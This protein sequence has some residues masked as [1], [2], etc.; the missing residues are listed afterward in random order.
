MAHTSVDVQHFLLGNIRVGCGAF[1]GQVSPD[2]KPQQACQSKH[3]E[4]RR[5]PAIE[6][7]VD[8]DGR[9]SQ[10]TGQRESNDFSDVH[11]GHDKRYHERL[12]R[13]RHPEWKEV[14]D[15]REGGTLKEAYQHAHEQRHAE[16]VP[17]CHGHQHRQKRRNRHTMGVPHQ[18]SRD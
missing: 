7:S 15:C 3:I 17:T 2:R 5:P 18:Y 1:L 9:A 4:D 11:T 10:C 8:I 14:V 6:V 16:G 13:N 12:L